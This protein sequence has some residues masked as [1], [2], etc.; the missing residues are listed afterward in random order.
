MCVLCVCARVHRHTSFPQW[1]YLFFNLFKIFSTTWNVTLPVGGQLG[2][3]SVCEK[4]V[5]FS[6]SVPF[7]SSVFVCVFRS[8]IVFMDFLLRVWHVRLLLALSAKSSVHLVE[9]QLGRLGAGEPRPACGQP[10]PHP[11]RQ[12]FGKT[13]CPSSG[14]P[15]SDGFAL[16]VHCGSFPPTI[17]FPSCK[18]PGC[19]SSFPNVRLTPASCRQLSPLPGPASALGSLH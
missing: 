5:N 13:S 9:R 6:V 14:G 7:A 10:Q 16:P 15:S 12:G 2:F 17:L 19:L 18:R 1:W 8:F 11:A 4:P 3:P